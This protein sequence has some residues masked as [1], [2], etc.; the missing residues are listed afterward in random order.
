VHCNAACCSVK[1][2]GIWTAYQ[3]AIGG[4]LVGG[5]GGI[6][7]GIEGICVRSKGSMRESSTLGDVEATGIEGRGVACGLILLIWSFCWQPPLS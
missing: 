7:W 3:G 1:T 2:R 4:E 5:G 6:G